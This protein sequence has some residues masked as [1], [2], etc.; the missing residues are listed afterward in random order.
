MVITQH[1]FDRARERMNLSEQEVRD[2][3]RMW[4][5][6][7]CRRQDNWGYYLKGKKMIYAWERTLE[8][9]VI[10]TA[11]YKFSLIWE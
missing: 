4:M 11:L 6:I 8:W 10:K 7:G 2:D 5:S 3:I 1:V 9:F